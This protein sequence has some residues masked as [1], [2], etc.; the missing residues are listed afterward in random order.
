MVQWYIMGVGQRGRM[1]RR[2]NKGKRVGG[3]GSSVREDGGGTV[4]WLY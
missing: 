3:M 1:A 4:M 2:R